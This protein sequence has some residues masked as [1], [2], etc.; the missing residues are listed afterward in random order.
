LLNRLPESTI[1]LL[2]PTIRSLGIVLPFQLDRALLGAPLPLSESL[3]L[4]WP[5]LTSLI[6]A[7]ILLFVI[8]YI[9]FPRQEL[10]A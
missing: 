10:R 8:G 4:I 1:M 6:A 2:Q 7:T 3:S 9:F 5:Q